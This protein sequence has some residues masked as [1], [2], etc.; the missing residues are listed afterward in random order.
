MSILDRLIPTPALLEIDR[1]E[2]AAAAVH[3]W[4]AVRGLDLAQ[5]AVVR[6]LFGIRTIPDRLAGHKAHL[7]LRIDDLTSTPDRPGFQRLAEEAR[8]VAAGAIGKV[9]RP[10]IPF[11][12]VHDAAAF[13]DFSEKGYVKVA[14]AIRV[15]PENEQTSC[16]EFEL[17]V[18][19]TDDEAWKK[20]S[21]Y[22]RLIGPGSHFIRRILLAQLARDLGTPESVQN[23]R[24]LPGDDAIPDAAGQ[25]T[26]ST[27][28]GAPPEKVWPWLVQMGG[29]RAGFYSIDL[30]DND[31][32]PSAREIRPNLQQLR[33]GD[34]IPSRPDADDH[35][36]VLRIQPARALLLGMLFDVENQRQLPFDAPRPHRF[37]QVS[38]AFVLEPLD[39]ERTRLYARARA[40]FPASERFHAF[41]IRPLHHLMQTAQLRHLAERAEGRGSSGGLRDAIESVGG[42]IAA[43]LPAR[44]R[45]R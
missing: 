16:A 45:Q 31:G 39:R 13:A 37:W 10:V 24:P 44:H 42:A 29:G 21:R 41:W 26:H 25:F 3:A 9:W 30:L 11:V 27:V 28:I 20:F 35:F 2:L 36:E 14:W 1:V 5:S 23:D 18:S 43:A 38:W 32:V 17:R 34:R 15:V 40:A 12:H 33:V 22:F 8:E 6:T 7:R 19:A 4:E